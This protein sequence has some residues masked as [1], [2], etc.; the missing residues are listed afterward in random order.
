MALTR[1][2]CLPQVFIHD[3]LYKWALT[4]AA[5]EKRQRD[6][7]GDAAADGSPGGA[8]GDAG[9]GEAFNADAE[10]ALLRVRGKLEGAENGDPPS[11]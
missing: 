7:A 4:A 5:A 2:R 8:A 10:R 6:G 9:A 3:P 11:P 1:V